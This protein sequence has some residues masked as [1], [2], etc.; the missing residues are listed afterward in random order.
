MPF[1]V[2]RVQQMSK[3]A[4]IMKYAYILLGE[5]LFS[6]ISFTPVL[7][8]DPIANDESR[9]DVDIPA[10]T[11]QR[12][13]EEQLQ[14]EENN[15]LE[16]EYNHY[17]KTCSVVHGDMSTAYDYIKTEV[18]DKLSESEFSKPQVDQ[19][20]ALAYIKQNY[21]YDEDEPMPAEKQAE[22]E[23]KRSDYLFE[24][25]TKLKDISTEVLSRLEKDKEAIEAAALGGC[26]A[27]QDIAINTQTLV[28]LV[29]QTVVDI[30]LQIQLM[31]LNAVQDLLTQPIDIHKKTE[32][33]DETSSE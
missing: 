3:G 13:I 28:A 21:F 4:G 23:K 18:F 6:F 26:G 17:T 16:D 19:E 15:Q 24:L 9:S 12:T 5:L 2:S 27:M 33:S 8:Y 14:E 32:T 10:E 20:A 7:A 30:T 22:I 31:E 11:V 1:R 25:Q 29:K